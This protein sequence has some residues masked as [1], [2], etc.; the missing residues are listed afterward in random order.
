MA[1]NVYGVTNRRP[2]T[3]RKSNS[4]FTF[5]NLSN[6]SNC[7]PTLMRPV[8]FRKSNPTF[9]VVDLPRISEI[10]VNVADAAHSYKTVDGPSECQRI[11]N[12]GPAYMPSHQVFDI[13]NSIRGKNK[14]IRIPMTEAR[15]RIL[16]TFAE[17]R[18]KKL[19]LPVNRD[20]RLAVDW[21]DKFRT[22]LSNVANARSRIHTWGY[23]PRSKSKMENLNPG[24]HYNFREVP[25]P[26]PKSTR[27]TPS[28]KKRGE[29]TSSRERC[30]CG[31]EV[32][33]I[34]DNFCIHVRN[35]KAKANRSTAGTGGK[36]KTGLPSN[37]K[38]R[39]QTPKTLPSD[40]DDELYRWDETDTQLV[41]SEP[42]CQNP[43]SSDLKQPSDACG[44]PDKAY[45]AVVEPV[46]SCRPGTFVK[47]QTP[48]MNSGSDCEYEGHVDQATFAVD[49]E[50]SSENHEYS[51][52]CCINDYL[53]SGV[54]FANADS[55][56]DL[57]YAESSS[58]PE[59][60]HN[61]S[62]HDSVSIPSE[63]DLFRVHFMQ[64]SKFP[65]SKKTAT[66]AD[67]TETTEDTSSSE[68]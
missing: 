23:A 4:M 32:C 9:P 59:S 54:E 50:D 39:G 60:S 33:S 5:A 44:T 53:D 18:K 3:Y 13:Y 29:S 45:L 63:E 66:S 58:G 22:H 56:K 36:P 34:Y 68:W 20:Q 27:S 55:E 42:E 14:D 28:T 57:K 49:G 51:G 38:V 35:A 64:R 21:E 46:E 6:A 12:V 19:V 26:R 61:E 67:N 1:T 37:N 31:K 62:D 2:V 7:G 40:S 11:K 47:Q 24:I 41:E 65:K 52:Q 48:S 10:K 8:T 15:K 17:S 43:I 30:G 16:K 25:S